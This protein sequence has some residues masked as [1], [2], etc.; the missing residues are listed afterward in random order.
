VIFNFQLEKPQVL[1]L[2]LDLWH[3]AD[4]E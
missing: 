1:K 2:I 4:I 3:I